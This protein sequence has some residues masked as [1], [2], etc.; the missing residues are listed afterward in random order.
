MRKVE[1]LELIGGMIKHFGAN[2]GKLDS[3]FDL[4]DGFSNTIW[5]NNCIEKLR[6]DP[7]SARM[8][9][10]RYMGPKYCLNKK[11]EKCLLSY[12]PAHENKCAMY[13]LEIT[14]KQEP[15]QTPNT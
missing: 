3:V 5:M 9:E 13:G 11:R 12:D 7:A 15:Q 14:R 6:K 1:N 8:L 2:P 4:E 10:E